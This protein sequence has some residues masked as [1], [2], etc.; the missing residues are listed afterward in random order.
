[1][2]IGELTLLINIELEAYESKTV[3]RTIT[4]YILGDYNVTVG[5]LEGNF[6][7]KFHDI[8]T[9]SLPPYFSDLTITPSEPKRGDN[10]TISIDIRNPNSKSIAT[11]SPCG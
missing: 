9:P 3:S 1:M 4:Q 8:P 5:S 11:E 7:V 2:Q 10:V 6:T